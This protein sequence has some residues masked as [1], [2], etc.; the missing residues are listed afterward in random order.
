[1]SRPPSPSR[2]VITGAPTPMA[3]RTG[4]MPSARRGPALHPPRRAVGAHREARRLGEVGTEDVDAT[5]VGREHHLLAAARLEVG[6]HRARGA[7][8]PDPPRQPGDEVG[9]SCTKTCFWLTPSSPSVGPSVGGDDDADADG[10]A[11]LVGAAGGRVD[12]RARRAAERG[13]DRREVER[14]ERP[15]LG[16]AAGRCL[17]RDH[18]PRR[19]HRGGPAAADRSPTRPGTS[20]GSRAWRGHVPVDRDRAGAR[21]APRTSGAT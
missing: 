19:R 8:A 20:T 13:G 2:S 9:S 10:E 5:V 6:E 18:V 7:R 15:S 11:L 17:R 1:M 3:L 14:G 12:R 16:P 21:A 4:G